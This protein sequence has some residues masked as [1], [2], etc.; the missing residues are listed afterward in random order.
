MFQPNQV[1]ALEFSPISDTL[2]QVPPPKVDYLLNA[3]NYSLT[4]TDPLISVTAQLAVEMERSEMNSPTA[5]SE[6]SLVLNNQTVDI[7]TNLTQ[8]ILCDANYSE[9]NFPTDSVNLLNWLY[10]GKDAQHI[11]NPNITSGAKLSYHCAANGATN[12]SNYWSLT[13]IWPTVDNPY[14]ATETEIFP[15][16]TNAG[17]GLFVFNQTVLPSALAEYASSILIFYATVVYIIATTFR[18]AF[19]PR[20]NEIFVIDAVN[21]LDLLMV[22]QCIYIYRV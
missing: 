17:F 3:L 16:N 15:V 11:A 19:V 10:T 1:Q 13:Q 4:G 7:T 21:T 20:T 9:A 22:C 8:M 18:S 6:T 12:Q 2:W 5:Y 14:L